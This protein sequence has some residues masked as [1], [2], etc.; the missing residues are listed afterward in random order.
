MDTQPIN[1]EQ[2]TINPDPITTSVLPPTPKSSHLLPMLLSSLVTA[3]ILVGIYFLFLN[4]TPQTITSNPSPSTIASP[5][6]D[7]TNTTYEDPVF[8]KISGSTVVAFE[9]PLSNSDYIDAR[10]MLIKD[11]VEPFIQYN[12]E[13][14]GKGYVVSLLVSKN[15][16]NPQ[17][18][19][20]LVAI[21]KNGGQQYESLSNSQ[22]EGQLWWSPT[23]QGSC[24]LSESFRTKY[25][26]ITKRVE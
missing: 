10:N 15:D 8:G 22:Y 6:P 25:P 1:L 14:N 5:S 26:E 17:Y 12:D 21:N 9:P 13:T 11:V 23:C 18:P 2:P 24:K 19:Y 20:R 16:T 7:S 3:L 4:K